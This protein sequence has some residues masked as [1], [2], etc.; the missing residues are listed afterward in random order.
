MK[1]SKVTYIIILI[2][3][4]FFAFLRFEELQKEDEARIEFL[5]KNYSKSIENTVIS[6]INVLY[7]LENSILRD[8][9]EYTE[10][11]FISVAEDFY[12]KDIHRCIYYLDGGIIRYI[13]SNNP[14]DQV[15]I[16]FNVFSDGNSTLEANYSKET[17]K[18]T[19]S[20]PHKL[21]NGGLGIIARK[22]VYKDNNKDNFIGFASVIIAPQAFIKSIDIK[23]IEI[24]G[25]DYSIATINN[26]KEAVL[27]QSENY[28]STKAKIH[29]FNLGVT[30]W[31]LA[32]YNTSHLK[33]NL[34]ALVI[35]VLAYFL[36]AT[37][38]YIMLVR[39][40][41]RNEKQEENLCIDQLTKAYNRKMIDEYFEK[42]PQLEAFTLF[43]ID[44]DDFKPVNDNFGHEIG[45]KLLIAFTE[46]AKANFKKATPFIRMGGDEF[47]I[48][49]EQEY[50]DKMI[51][52][53]INRISNFANAP[54]YIDS[55]IIKISAS[56]GVAQFPYDGDTMES[57]LSVADKKMYDDKALKKYKN[58]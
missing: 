38:A 1:A 8:N 18:I 43:Y 7:P 5:L 36:G 49:I 6:S 56:I 57:L 39:L 52:S 30:T 53:T 19:V 31:R 3:G 35:L 15:A 41:K 37:F 4:S 48:I 2:V 55:H 51:Q 23:N 20:G 21:Y 50:N 9:D 27:V 47:A 25:Y 58:Q 14:N 42:N 10:E 45:D 26:G 13:Y 44:L 28:E 29:D 32:I 33:S 12:N 24:I 40:E 34:E 46:R 22:P 16:G 54:F 11:E 17:G